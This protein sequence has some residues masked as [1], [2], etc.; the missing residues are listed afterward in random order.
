MIQ[1]KLRT[2]EERP[3]HIAVAFAPVALRVLGELLAAELQLF[4]GGL[5]REH[6]ESSSAV[7]GRF[8]AQTRP[9]QRLPPRFYRLLATLEYDNRRKY[10][11]QHVR[12]DSHLVAD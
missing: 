5:P 6:G 7:E 10:A 1:R 12:S 4:F 11:G 9:A 8:G 3:Q 2:I